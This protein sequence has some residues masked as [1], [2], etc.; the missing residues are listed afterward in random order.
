MAVLSVGSGKPYSTITA[1]VAAAQNGDTIEVQAGI[2]TNQ[3]VSISKNIT[4][5]GVGGMVKM[6]STGLI[7]NGKGI[8]ITNGNIT[9]NNFEFSGAKVYHA[10]GAGIRYESGNLVLNNT[11]FHHNQ[12][13]LL[14]ASNIA[15]SITINNSE[16][17]YNGRGDGQTHNLYVS[18]IANLKID[19][20]YF[21]DAK[22]GH[23]IKSRALNTTITNS[24]IYDLNGTASYSIDLPN[25]GK[26]VIQNNIIQQG[27]YSQNSVIISAGAEGSL[28][29]GTSLLI[30]GNT[31]INDKSGWALAVRNVTT[32]TAQITGNDFYGLTSSQIA[33]GSNTQTGSQF[34]PTRPS[35]DTTQPWASQSPTPPGTLSIILT[36]DT[37]SSATDKITSNPAIKGVGQANTLVTIKEGGTTLGT[38]TANSTGAWSFTPSGL[39][40][41]A[42]T[43]TAI[44]TGNPSTATL[45]FTLDRT[46]PAMSIALVSDTGN[47]ATDKIT[48][49]PAIKGVGQAGTVVTI[50]EGGATL[51]TTTADSAGAWSFTPSGL[52]D[53]AH[54]LIATQ[55]DPAGNTGTATLSFTLDSGLASSALVGTESADVLV[56]SLA[57]LNV[58]YGLGG[59]DRISVQDGKA[60]TEIYGGNGNDTIK[61]SIW[62]TDYI[63]GG[64]GNDFLYGYWE[65]DTLLG[66][67]GD[68]WIDAGAGD[69]LVYTGGGNDIIY[70]NYG[71]DTIHVGPGNN[72][73]EGGSGTD[74]AVL[75]GNYAGY[76]LS[77][78]N[79][80]TTVA[81]AEGTS[82]FTTVEKLQFNNGSYDVPAGLFTA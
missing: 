34:L 76:S 82:T 56:G 41:G 48:S 79:N 1:A 49:N 22:V 71:N 81:G 54:T 44:Q 35:L 3:Y 58:I 75:S 78:A 18:K 11:Y 24:R 42:H 40:D 31:I 66:G 43:L 17:A 52:I 15:G 7:P 39:A 13:G 50:K 32:A 14:S 77:S 55:T 57:G 25:G 74:I 12:N 38:T 19:N 27:P 2:Y 80:V 68:D 73:V 37:G 30:S 26:A 16:F 9:I 47:S 67:E 72:R 53:G 61:G 59:N 33:S 8:F 65:D 45:S 23:E 20:S 46:A 6:V 21:H 29:P 62:G 64:P 28:I 60:T 5:Q 36:S 69:D 70:G 10:N 4:L 51:G 63:D